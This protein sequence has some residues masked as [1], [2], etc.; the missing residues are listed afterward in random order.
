MKE[1][2]ST[3]ARRGEKRAKEKMKHVCLSKLTS[4]QPRNGKPT[5]TE[6]THTCFGGQRGIATGA[7]ADSASTG[8]GRDG[9]RPL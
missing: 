1:W 4:R 2:R 5:W 3:N 6:M 9:G 8:V 7:V